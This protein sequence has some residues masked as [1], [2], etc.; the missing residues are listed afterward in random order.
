MVPL[1][2]EMCFTEISD[3]QNGEILPILYNTWN[4]VLYYRD[5]LDKLN[6][7]DNIIIKR[8]KYI[9]FNTT[10]KVSNNILKQ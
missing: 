1:S 7:L 9:K 3:R 6:E 8:T 2:W 4:R 5:N 10:I